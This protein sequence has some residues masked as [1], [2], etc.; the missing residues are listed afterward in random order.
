VQALW[1]LENS[2]GKASIESLVDAHV[3][4]EGG[5][6][7]QADPAAVKAYD[8]AYGEYSRYLVA[9]SPLYK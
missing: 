6:T 5:A 3:I 2:K 4:L 1:A 9:L 8:R 7:V